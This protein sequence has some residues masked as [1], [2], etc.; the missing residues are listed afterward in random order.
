MDII[1]SQ[2]EEIFQ[3][4]KVWYRKKYFKRS[5]W[6]RRMLLGVNLYG[7][8]LNSIYHNIKKGAII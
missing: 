6:S 5:L 4:T 1:L 8:E 7:R 2:D 3:V